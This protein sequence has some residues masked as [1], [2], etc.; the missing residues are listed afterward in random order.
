[1]QFF[2]KL[3]LKDGYHH[4]RI[5]QGDEKYT[6]FI[7]VACFGLKNAPAEFARYMRRIPSYY[8]HLAGKRPKPDRS[9]GASTLFQDFSSIFEV[10]SENG[11]PLA[12]SVGDHHL[13]GFKQRKIFFLFLPQVF[14]QYSLGS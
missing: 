12:Q 9:G 8:V 1:L 3:D 4:L 10:R 7:T 2:T 5:R 14:S 6:A 11:S 13:F